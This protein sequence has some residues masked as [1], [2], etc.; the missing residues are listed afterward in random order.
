MH[1][2]TYESLDLEM[3]TDYIEAIKGFPA[4]PKPEIF[5]LH[6]NADITCDQNE[7]YNLFSTILAL[8]PRVSAG[9]G[10]SREDTLV[11]L[12]ETIAGKV[13]TWAAFDALCGCL[14]WS[15]GP[16]GPHLGCGCIA[17]NYTLPCK[18]SCSAA[19]YR[20]KHSKLCLGGCHKTHSWHQCAES[21]MT[22]CMHLYRSA[23]QDARQFT[24]NLQ[25]ACRLQ[26][27]LMW[28]SSSASTPPL[29]RSP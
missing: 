2:G 4:L 29:I 14:C 3:V 16:S 7:T 24:G 8:Q 18:Q 25:P 26:R 1:A 15:Q 9:T 28:T 27:R 17:W 12:C 5:G 11:Q 13:S 22:G 21:G 20:C 23:A 6:E 19:R 10:A